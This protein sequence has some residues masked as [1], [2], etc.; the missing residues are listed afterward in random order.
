MATVPQRSSIDQFSETAANYAIS[1]PHNQGESL[2]LV[3]AFIA[4]GGRRFGTA[5]DIATGPGFT[6]FAAAPHAERVLATDPT[7]PMLDQVRLIRDERGLGNVGLVMVIAEQLPFADGSLDLLTCR[8]APHHFLD[9]TRW[10]GEVA[11]VLA[12]GGVFVLCDTTAPE[13][14]AVGAW[15]NDLEVRRD[16]SHVR[17]WTPTE[18][19]TGVEGAGLNITDRGMANVLLD[20]EDWVSRSATPPDVAAGIEADLREASAAVR[21]SFGIEVGSGSRI[22]WH[23]PVV[24]LRAEKPRA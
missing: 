11:R 12:P 22:D 4:K 2:G 6:A 20:Y 13:D 8:T 9:V 17:N 1:K 21:A 15:M 3:S 24:V 19:A 16:P 7:R 5:V 18:W 14:P 10:L 23:W